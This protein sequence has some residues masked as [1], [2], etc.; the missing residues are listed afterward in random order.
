MGNKINLDKQDSIILNSAFTFPKTIFESPTKKYVDSL[1]ENRRNRGDLSTVFNDQGNQFDNT[2]LTILDSVTVNGNPTSDNE[3]ST[4]TYIDDSIG[5]GTLSRFNQTLENYLKVSVAKDTYNL[6]EYD[7]IQIT[8][9]TKDF[10][11]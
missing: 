2:K 3:S 9:T 8:G 5:E 10:S 4:K 7:K 1:H 6:T 11:K